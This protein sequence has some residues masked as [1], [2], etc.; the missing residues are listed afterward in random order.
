MKNHFLTLLRNRSTKTPDFRSAAATLASILAN[1]IA[2]QAE[3]APHKVTT[4]LGE[5]EGARLETPVILIPILR[6]GLVFLPPFLKLFPQASI[7]FLGIRRDEK[8]ARPRL[9][10]ENIPEFPPQARIYLLDPMLATGGTANLALER[11]ANRGA[12]P[13]RTLLATFLAARQGMEAVRRQHP[14]VAIH[15]AAVDPDL[16][17]NQFIVPGLGDF[18]DRYF[19][20]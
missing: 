7:G 13:Q 1:E 5:A 8:D 11:I 15:T 3:L 9:Y 14:A 20:T 16:D 17:P 2:P 19:G 4:P 12:A 10:Y 6:A 18:G